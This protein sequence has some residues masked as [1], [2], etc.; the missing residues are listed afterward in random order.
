MIKMGYNHRMSLLILSEES[1]Y[2]SKR[3]D[4]RTH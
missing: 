1:A 4:I 2:D 3:E